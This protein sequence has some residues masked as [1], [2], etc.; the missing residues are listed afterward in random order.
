MRLW[1]YEAMRLWGYEVM[2]L[3]GYEVM[4]LWGYEVMRLWGYEA[5][6]QIRAQST[7]TMQNANKPAN[8]RSTLTSLVYSY[9][10]TCLLFL[11]YEGCATCKQAFESNP[12][13]YS[14]LTTCLLFL[15]YE[16][17]SLQCFKTVRDLP[18]KKNV[19]W[20]TDSQCT[21]FIYKKLIY[22]AYWSN[23]I[24]SFA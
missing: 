17:A 10:T 22:L 23:S 4:R 9:L 19:H 20:K 7:T 11:G 2:R 15:G 6:Q 16:V 5:M 13:V 21:F 14:Y 24:P 12:L 3:W 1:G 18:N 8:N